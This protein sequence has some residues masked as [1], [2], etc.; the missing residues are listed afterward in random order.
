MDWLFLVL[1]L[2]IALF[3]GGI[4]VLCYADSSTKELLVGVIA[5][6]MDEDH[7]D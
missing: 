3:T 5:L 6:V 2:I 4:I 7:H 1:V